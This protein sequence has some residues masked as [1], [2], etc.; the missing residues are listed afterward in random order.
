LSQGLLC[1]V[2]VKAGASR[3]EVAWV[4]EKGQLS[5]VLIVRV[6][7]VPERG[8]A[9]AAVIETLAKAFGLPKSTIRITKGA[10]A[11]TKTLFIAGDP[12]RLLEKLGP[13]LSALPKE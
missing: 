4:C 5:E 10:R 8:K 13:A 6:R 2:R 12:Q 11:R 1:V 3:E 9:N 7:A